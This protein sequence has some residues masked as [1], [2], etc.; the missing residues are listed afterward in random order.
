MLKKL[1][2]VQIY[3]DM[4]P[5]PSP[6]ESSLLG[7]CKKTV[8][9]TVLCNNLYIFM[10]FWSVQYCSYYNLFI[11]SS[12]LTWVCC[13]RKGMTF[14]ELPMMIV[15]YD[16]VSLGIEKVTFFCYYTPNLL[17][18]S[19]KWYHDFVANLA[20]IFI[21]IYNYYQNGLSNKQTI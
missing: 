20:T 7:G 18:G 1:F 11:H 9:L 14:F 16:T 19:L 2:C 6:M 4:G 17:K 13:T 3:G 15:V 10:L 8:D 5:H 21:L 12:I